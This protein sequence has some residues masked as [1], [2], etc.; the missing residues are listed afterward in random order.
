MGRALGRPRNQQYLYQ[1][2]W[3]LCRY[4]ISGRRI[5]SGRGN[6]Q[7]QDRL[8]QMPPAMAGA[9]SDR[10]GGATIEVHL[11]NSVRSGDS[12]N[13][14]VAGPADGWACHQLRGARGVRWGRRDLR[15]PLGLPGPWVG[16][17]TPPPPQIY[18]YRTQKKIKPRHIRLQML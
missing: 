1:L 15:W 7:R 18:K 3:R 16:E 12:K 13:Q 10:R 6:V 2:S 4:E 5:E 9:L 8:T 11:V 14:N 17:G